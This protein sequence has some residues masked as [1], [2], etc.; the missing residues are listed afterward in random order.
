M[1]LRPDQGFLSN[2]A[3]R[4]V[5][6]AAGWGGTVSYD[7]GVPASCSVGIEVPVERLA[8]DE[9]ELRERL[10]YGQPVSESDRASIRRSML[11]PDQLDGARFPGI[12]FA[13]VG[14]RQ[15]PDR[16]I[17]VS[18]DLEIRGRKKRI[19][20]P[21]AARLVDDR[22]RAEGSFTV[23]HADFGFSPYSALLGAIRNDE[24]LRFTLNLVGSRR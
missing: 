11:G 4:H 8:V 7:A 21:L 12:R 23:T 3:H 24:A 5:I 19:A 15:L 1:E 17:E 9:P 13:S 14:C 22:L 2:L 6:R 10:A 18:G 20:V 16:R